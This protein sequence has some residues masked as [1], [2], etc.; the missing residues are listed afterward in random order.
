MCRTLEKAEV[1]VSE[2]IAANDGIMH[3]KYLLNNGLCIN[4]AF[5]L[6][7]D[8]IENDRFRLSYKKVVKSLCMAMLAVKG[9]YYLSEYI[10]AIK[11]S[12]DINGIMPDK[13]DYSMIDTSS[14]K[15]K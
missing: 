8:H 7:A 15:D 11:H 4:Y 1:S 12:L 5:H 14:S 9:D 13:D 10:Q 6:I 2:V 3:H